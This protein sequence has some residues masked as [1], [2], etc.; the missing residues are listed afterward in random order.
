MKSTLKSVLFATAGKAGLLAL[1]AGGGI[2]AGGAAYAQDDQASAG[3]SDQIIVSAR[4]REESLQDVPL[5]V[6]A[7]S[8]DQLTELGAQDLTDIEAIAPNVTLETS[9]ATN[10]T[11]T[12]FIRGVGQQDPVSGFESGVG[13]YVDDVYYARVASATTF[14]TWS[15]SRCCAGR[16][17]RSTAATPSAAR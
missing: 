8:G 14:T 17:E 7:F 2:A 9:R 13:I 11:L 10:S 16:R 15:A 3:V 5:A 4:R 1:C 6:S 12:A